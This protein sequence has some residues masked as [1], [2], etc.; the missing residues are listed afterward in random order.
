MTYYRGDLRDGLISVEGRGHYDDGSGRPEDCHKEIAFADSIGGAA[1]GAAQFLGSG[2]Y[3]EV[4]P[5]EF[6][7]QDTKFTVNIYKTD[8]KPDY[9]VEPKAS[10]FSLDVTTDF[11]ITGEVRFCDRQIPVNKVCSIDVTGHDIAVLQSLLHRGCQST[12][13]NLAP[14][15]SEKCHG[16]DEEYGYWQDMDCYTEYQNLLERIIR[17][18]IP[19]M[20]ETVLDER[21][22]PDFECE[23]LEGIDQWVA[24]ILVEMFASRCNS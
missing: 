13:F 14:L 21:K 4:D 12:F 1:Y 7:Y 8:E 16:Q 3:K 2:F 11:D 17:N 19:L 15:M 6:L 18:D 10:D 9:R 23:Q 5:K 22:P 24:E 20:E